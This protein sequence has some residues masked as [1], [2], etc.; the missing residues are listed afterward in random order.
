MCWP[1]SR[2]AP[3]RWAS[4]SASTDLTRAP[5]SRLTCS[6]STCSRP[7]ITARSLDL[8]PLVER[9]HAAGALVAVGTD[10]LA[11]TLMT[12]PGE[13]GADVVVGNAQRFGVPLGYGGPH[14]A[15]FATREK[16]VRQA[17]GRDHRRVGGLEGPPRVP[18]G[19]ADA[20]AAHPAREGDVEHLHGAGAAGQHGG[21]LRGVPRPRGPEGHRRARARPGRHDWPR[22][23][24]RSAGRRRTARISTRCASRPTHRACRK[25]RDGRGDP[26][27]QPPLPRARR[28]ADLTE[29]DRHRER[30]RRTSLSAF[31]SARAPA[32][33]GAPG[34][35]ASIALP[36]ALRR[37]SGVPG[38]SGV[39]RA[40]LRDR[41]DAV[42]P[43]ARA[44]G[45]RARHGDDSARVLHDEAERRGGNDAGQLAGVLAH[46]PVRPDRAG[47]GLSGDLPRARS[48]RSATSRASHA[49]SLQPNSGAQG[50]YAGLLVIRAYHQSRGDPKRNV[51]LIP[52]SAHGTN[53]ASASLAGMVV[54]IVACD[55]RG[56]I[57]VDD[58]RAE[59]RELPRHA[60]VPDGDVP[61]HA[62][63]V[64][65]SASVRSARSCT[66]TAARCTWTART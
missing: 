47:G 9:A 44:Q 12:P 15:F 59:G 14:A 16:F 13:A 35:A 11:L 57:D 36:A 10:L 62:R 32:T 34:S 5:N 63:R 46:A 40:S 45:H 17:P 37:T 49:V 48:R 64:R 61:E 24:A 30:P 4:S 33:I 39:Q 31:A 21:V 52:Q 8:T 66:S 6:A 28:R 26:R 23:L 22:R 43:R 20:R 41:D 65:G 18:H 56:N 42:H 25:V 38:A 60:V 50:E 58:L 27:H 7:T 51:V 2:A 1:C 3:N 19:A 54:V 53:P 55:D 29:R